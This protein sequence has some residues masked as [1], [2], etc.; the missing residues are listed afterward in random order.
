MSYFSCF[1]YGVNE[2]LTYFLFH[3]NI[4]SICWGLLKKKQHY[5]IF[6][7]KNLWYY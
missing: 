4:L 6:S 5:F 3:I 7:Y 1:F 2:T